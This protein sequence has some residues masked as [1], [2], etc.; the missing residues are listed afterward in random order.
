MKTAWMFLCGAV[1][2]VSATSFAAPSS[3][4]VETY[5]INVAR[6]QLGLKCAIARADGGSV[7]C[8]MNLKAEGRFAIEMERETDSKKGFVG[9]DVTADDFGQYMY[10]L[11]ADA[12]KKLSNV[13]LMRVVQSEDGKSFEGGL[14]VVES[15]SVVALNI[16]SVKVVLGDDGVIHVDLSL[17]A[18]A[19]ALGE[20]MV[21]KLD[22]QALTKL[23]LQKIQPLVR[24][25]QLR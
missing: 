12:D 20:N 5:A 11:S 14:S 3:A 24:A 15:T 16:P 4:E 13:T 7:E 23:A 17:V 22:K 21:T 25:V 9:M 2:A 6:A 19:P 8:T 18:Y 10:I 1:L